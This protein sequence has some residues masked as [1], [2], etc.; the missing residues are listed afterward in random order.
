[1]KPDENDPELQKQ[2]Q[3]MKESGSKGFDASIIDEELD[4]AELARMA[5]VTQSITPRSPE[6]AAVKKQKRLNG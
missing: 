4:P 5:K 1:M 2:I 3:E 6:Q